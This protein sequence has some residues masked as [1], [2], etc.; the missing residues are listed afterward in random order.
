MAKKVF[1]FL[2][3]GVLAYSLGFSPM[4]NVSTS[5]GGSGV[6]LRNSAWGLYYN[7]AL[8]SSDP[9]SKFSF[10]GGLYLSRTNLNEVL[11]ITTKN[12][13]A[14]VQEMLN[15]LKNARGRLEAQLGVVAQIGGFVKKS[16]HTQEDEYGRLISVVK[17][18]QSSAIGIGA[19]ASSIVDISIAGDSGVNY[20]ASS[21][22]VVIMEIPVGYAYKLGSEFGDFNFGIAMKYLR[23]VFERNSYQGNA[24]NGIEMQIPNFLSMSPSQNFGIDLGFLYSYSDFHIGITAKNI[25]CP[26]F[27]NDSEKIRLDPQLRMGMSYEF[28]SHYVF[29]MDIDLLP[30]N[31]YS[32]ATPKSQYFGV[33]IMGD[34]TKFDFRLGISMDMLGKDGARLSAGFNAFGIIDIVGEM[35]TNFVK[36]NGSKL[37][38]PT[39]FGFK[40]GSTFTF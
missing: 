32:L 37:A 2:T 24:Y 15:Q 3:S 12:D 28:A 1:V 39:D 16:I 8:L 31:S 26:K 36:R 19:F 4:G 18:E 29:V 21:F 13:F 17:E 35:G 33:G 7:P 38:T 6:A 25:N 5:L 34:Y 9:R 40:V 10:S 11:E 14:Q 30:Y 27:K 20:K 22:G 23:A